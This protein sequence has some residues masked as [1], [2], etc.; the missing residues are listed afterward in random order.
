MV[1]DLVLEL[2]KRVLR[3]TTPNNALGRA[4]PQ[5]PGLALILVVLAVLVDGCSRRAVDATFV[6]RDLSASLAVSSA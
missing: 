5:H 6:R 4:L 3:K 2:E 1:Q